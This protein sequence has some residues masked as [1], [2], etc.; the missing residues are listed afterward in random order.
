[1]FAD[2]KSQINVICSESNYTLPNTAYNTGAPGLHL[3]HLMGVEINNRDTSDMVNGAELKF[4]S[5][6]TPITML[7]LDPSERV[8]RANKKKG[9]LR[10]PGAVE[11]MIHQFG[12]TNKHGEQAFRHMVKGRIMTTGTRVSGFWVHVKSGRINVLHDGV[13]MASWDADVVVNALISKMRR[14][15]L[16]AG[17][18]SGNR[19]RY[20]AATLH[21]ELRASRILKLIADG[22]IKIDFD[23]KIKSNGVV[24]NHGVKWRIDHADLSKLYLESEVICDYI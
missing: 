16:V 15:F 20:D 8:Q 17:K 9:T 7:H 23:A 13:I 19:V 18:R 24:R 11:N 6:T 1:M 10:I 3:E 5:K 2:T 21:R 4:T 12:Y 22:V 14:M